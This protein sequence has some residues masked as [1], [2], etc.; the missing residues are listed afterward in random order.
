[1]TKF[2]IPNKSQ[3][4]IIQKINLLGFNLGFSAGGRSSSGGTIL[5][6]RFLPEAGRNMVKKI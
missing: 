6:V 4:Q 1:M 2:K 3:T 5:D